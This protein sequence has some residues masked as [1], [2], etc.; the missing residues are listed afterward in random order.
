MRRISTLF[1]KM[2]KQDRKLTMTGFL[3][4]LLARGMDELDTLRRPRFRSR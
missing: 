4:Q 2:K 3:R 1:S